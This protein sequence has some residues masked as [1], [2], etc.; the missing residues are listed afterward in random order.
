MSAQR[1]GKQPTKPR[2]SPKDLV[3][4]TGIEPV[5]FGSG[6]RRHCDKLLDLSHIGNSCGY[7]LR[8]LALQATLRLD[9][10]PE[11][12]AALRYELAAILRHV[13]NDEPPPV[14]ERLRAIAA[15]FEA[16][17]SGRDSL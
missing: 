9:D 7:H 6:G 13:A 11:V 1:R 8:P 16:G 2:R 10:M 4:P 12:L 15:A 5:A 3:R 17:Q 14:A